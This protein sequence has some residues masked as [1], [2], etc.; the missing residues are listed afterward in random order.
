M[1]K[2]IADHRVAGEHWMEHTS[3][4]SSLKKRSQFHETMSGASRIEAVECDRV[5]LIA[6]EWA[7]ISHSYHRNSPFGRGAFDL[8]IE[9]HQTSRLAARINLFH[10]NF[11]FFRP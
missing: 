9:P 1:A 3:G 10:H 5:P 2:K 7:T 4:G 11:N 8:N 6:F